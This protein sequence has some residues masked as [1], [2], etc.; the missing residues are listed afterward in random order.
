MFH[1][2]VLGYVASPTDRQRFADAMH[3]SAAI[4]ISNEAPGVFPAIAALAPSP[5]RGRFLLAVNGH[6]VAWTGPHGQSIDWF[7]SDTTSMP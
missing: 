1:T 4:W 2:A 3:R 5:I 6:P 7:A